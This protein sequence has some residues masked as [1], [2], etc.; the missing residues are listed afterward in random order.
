[1]PAN[2][3]RGEVDLR[4]GDTT[5]T[6]TLKTAGAI[7]LQKHFSPADGPR[8]P[9]EQVFES[10][11]AGS[12]EHFVAVWWAS[13]LKYHP[14]IT[15]EQAVDLMDDAGGIGAVAAQMEDITQSTQPDPADVKA[16]GRNE[17]RPQKAQRRGT[18][19]DS[20][21]TPVAAA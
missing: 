21:S 8:T 2:P 18:G 14:E 15:F 19:A 12:I 11:F 7:A 5:Y 17:H 9:I 1:M 6:L 13:F 20:T 16:L 3:E 10:A 4:I